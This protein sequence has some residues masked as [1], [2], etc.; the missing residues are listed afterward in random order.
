MEFNIIFSL[1]GPSIYV[2]SLFNTFSLIGPSIYAF[3]TTSC[4]FMIVSNHACMFYDS[5]LTPVIMNVCNHACMYVCCFMTVCCFM[6]VCNHVMGW[7][8]SEPHHKKSIVKSVLITWSSSYCRRQHADLIT[9]VFYTQ[10]FL[11]HQH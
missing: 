3:K 7:S 8:F 10:Q 1:I 11:Q 2:T 9:I 6:I 4:C 5:L